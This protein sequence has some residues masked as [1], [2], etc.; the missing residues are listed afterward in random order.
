MSLDGKYQFEVQRKVKKGKKPKKDGA[1]GEKGVEF[2]MKERQ[3]E[4]SAPS[5]TK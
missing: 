2:E 3:G 5:V 1:E 4:N